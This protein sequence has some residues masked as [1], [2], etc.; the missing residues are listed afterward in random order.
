MLII[1][2]RY[3][4]GFNL[5]FLK[6]L[7]IFKIQTFTERLQTFKKNSSLEN[8]LYVLFRPED[9]LLM[10]QMNEVATERNH[11]EVNFKKSSP[12]SRSLRSKQSIKL[13]HRLQ[14]N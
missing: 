10:V 6:H 7:K 5:S 12:T 11:T 9:D 3:I 4:Q 13:L 8:V 14:R 1:L 2:I